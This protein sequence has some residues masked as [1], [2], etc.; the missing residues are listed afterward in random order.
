[1]V[2]TSVESSIKT[3]KRFRMLRMSDSTRES[4]SEFARM[5]LGFRERQIAGLVL[6]IA[7]IAIDID[8]TLPYGDCWAELG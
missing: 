6:A 5:K 4:V 7:H 2:I 1:M 8:N 3:G